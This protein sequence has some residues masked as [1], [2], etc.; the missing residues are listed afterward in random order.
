MKVFIEKTNETIDVKLKEGDKLVN[1]LDRLNINISSIIL[2]KNGE[3]CLEDSKVT[4]SDEIKILSVV[5]GG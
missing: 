3:V 4:D 2:V 5:S 1:I